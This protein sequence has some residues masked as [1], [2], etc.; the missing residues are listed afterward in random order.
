MINS[1]HPSILTRKDHHDANPFFH[2]LPPNAMISTDKGL[3]NSVFIN[4]LIILK[5][6]LF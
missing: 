5:L 4:N 3:E 6:E 2:F 1:I